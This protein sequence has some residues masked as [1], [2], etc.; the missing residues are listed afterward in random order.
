MVA[1]FLQE[2]GGDIGMRV[3][4]PLAVSW[5]WQQTIDG[6]Y[7]HRFWGLAVLRGGV[8]TISLAFPRDLTKGV[9]IVRNVV[10]AVVHCGGRWERREEGTKTGKRE[11][12]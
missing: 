12:S 7:H 8:I 6:V 5:N 11:G 3:S 1:A 2:W 9:G 4:G 10:H